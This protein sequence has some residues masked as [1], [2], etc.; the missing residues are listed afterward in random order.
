MS[1]LLPDEEALAEFRCK[2]S[3]A[4]SEP[5]LDAVFA[6]ASRVLKRRADRVE[7]LI[8][9][10]GLAYYEEGREIFTVN[11]IK[12]G[13]RLY[14]H[15]AAGLLFSETEDYGLEKVSLWKSSY[16]KSTRKYR[17]MSAWVTDESHLAGA[18]ALIDRLARG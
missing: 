10:V 15:P 2:L 1:D 3:A 17:G 12:G 13:L 9:R 7:R 6:H 11:V 16:Q 14:L 18:K 4:E 5:I 8:D